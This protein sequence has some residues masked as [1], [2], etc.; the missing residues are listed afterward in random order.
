MIWIQVEIQIVALLVAMACA[1]PG[2]FLV[3]RRVSLLSDA[4][5][6][7]VLLGIVLAFFLVQDLT[8]PA[9]LIGA[10][11][12]GL[13]TVALIEVVSSRRVA[14]DA[15]IGL[16]FPLLFS[17]GVILIARYAGDVHLDTDV[18]LLGELAFVPFDRLALAGFDLGPAA[19]YK[20]G[21]VLILNVG[22][23]TMLYKELKISTFDPALA[24]S[25]GFSTVL[26]HY[27]LMG[28][29]S[30]TA[31]AAFDAVG[32]ILV[33]AL[34]IAPPSA[35]YLLTDD[36]KVMILTSLG[37]GAFS[38]VAGFWLAHAVDASIAGSMATVTGASFVMAFLFAPKRG[39]IAAA[40]RRARQRWAFAEVML[41][42]HLAQHEGRSE[43]HVEN[44]LEHLEEG[45]HW[46]PAFARKVVASARRHGY[47]AEEGSLLRVTGRGRALARD[48]LM[49]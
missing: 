40:R 33:V 45:L 1:L 18:V 32:S 24:A 20:M 22:L 23:I 27:L 12:S 14:P 44:R 49:A 2:V 38:A 41:A 6:H 5:T 17:I 8:S 48:A 29:V 37:F 21:A 43:E 4:I 3:L 16:V 46:E 13:L 34:M 15:A 7:S 31:V 35:A 36:L 11:V 42:I 47:V 30:L 10:A 28:S 9:L 25:L 39:L 19:L 26:L